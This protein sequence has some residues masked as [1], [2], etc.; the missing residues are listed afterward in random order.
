MELEFFYNSYNGYLGLTIC[1]MIL[2]LRSLAFDCFRE[3]ALQCHLQ[4]WLKLCRSKFLL[5][6]VS[7]ICVAGLVVAGELV[8]D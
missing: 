5:L 1:D 2:F 7:F 6:L 3:L 4:L 8:V